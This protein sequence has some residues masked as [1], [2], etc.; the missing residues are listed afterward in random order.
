MRTLVTLV[1]HGT[2]PTE[3]AGL[4]NSV[5]QLRHDTGSWESPCSPWWQVM[6]GALLAHPGSLFPFFWFR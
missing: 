2:A 6:G 3:R 1:Q 4:G 5:G